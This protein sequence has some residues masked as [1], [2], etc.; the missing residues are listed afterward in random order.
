[1]F[2]IGVRIEYSPEPIAVSSSYNSKSAT[3]MVGLS[4]LGA[5]CYL[6]ALLQMLFHLPTFRRLIY[7]LSLPDSASNSGSSLIF[8]LQTI[9]YHLQHSTVEVSTEE[10]IK[11]FGWTTSDSFLQQDV[12]E[13]MRLLL[14]KLEELMKGT[15]CDGA[16]SRI[17]QG[18][19]RSFIRCLNIAYE[20]VREED[21]Y[22]IQLDVK[23][24]PDIYASF[25]QYVARELL[26]G[27]NQYDAG[28]SGGKQDAE[29]GVDFRSL[30]PVLTI[31][32]KR[33][34]FDVE[35]LVRLPLMLR[36]I[37]IL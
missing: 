3:G 35:R 25:K 22:D 30:P 2:K 21:F 31:H 1:M 32:L 13:M 26:D 20:S 36:H 28:E 37:L 9:F 29:K 16:I 24:C 33:F 19:L 15:D 7:S 12:Q 10:L 4:N 18:K 14:D 17:F 23:G 6:N 34:H 8:G 5:T 27:E 11:A